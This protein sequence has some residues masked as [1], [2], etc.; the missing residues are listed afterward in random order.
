MNPTK[1]ILSVVAGLTVSSS[2][3]AKKQPV[4]FSV[5]KGVYN[6]TVTLTQPGET[7]SGTA[8]VVINSPK[9]GLSATISYV[10]T[11]PIGDG[12]F[13]TAIT[14]GKDKSVFVTDIGVGIL[15]TNNAHKASGSTYLER[16]GKLSFF[17]TNGDTNFTCIA[18]VKDHGRK[19]VLSLTFVSA[20]AMT[21]EGLTFT[22][23]AT[24]KAPRQK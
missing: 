17:V 21:G 14:L 4:D 20:D 7:D 18:S 19:R 2:A 12:T 1:I 9:N 23:S 6:G 13:P 16:K 24:A 10:A 11:L 22:T 8:T 3:F 5:F 15:G